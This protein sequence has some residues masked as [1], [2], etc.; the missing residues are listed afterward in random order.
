MANQTITTAVN[1]DDASISGL[2]DGETITINGGQLT[3]NADVRYNQQAAVPGNLTISS[4]LG[5][6]IT[7]DGTEVWELYF[8][9]STGNVPTQAALGSNTV[10]SS[11]GATGELLR[12]W[13]TGS[14]TP[15]AAG[16]AMPA[17]GW[18]KL[19]SKTGNFADNEVVTLPGGATITLTGPGRRSWIEVAGAQGSQATIPRLG[20]FVCTGDW[21]EIGATDGTDNQTI[22]TPFVAEIPAIQIETASGSGQYEWW[23]NANYRWNARLPVTSVGGA[24]VTITAE[25]ILGPGPAYPNGRRIRETAVNSTH[26]AQLTVT[27]T[28]VTAGMLSV[29]AYLKQETRQYVMVQLS[30]SGG[31]NRYAALVDLVNGTIVSNSSVGSPTSP[32]SS[33]S[34][35]GGGWYKV[36]VSASHST[37]NIQ[38]IVAISDSATPTLNASGLPTYTGV[39]TEGTYLGDFYLENPAA[40]QYISSTDNRGKYFYSDFFEGKIVLAKRGT[41]NAGIKPASGCKIRIPNIILTNAQALDWSRNISIYYGSA[42]AYAV[43]ISSSG[44][45]DIDKTSFI[46]R[47]S[48]GTTTSFKLTNSAVIGTVGLGT[49]TSTSLINNICF[50]AAFATAGLVIS[51][52][53][54]APT[55]TNS[56]F[57]TGYNGASLNVANAA[58]VIIQNCRCDTHGAFGSLAKSDTAAA[59]AISNCPGAVVENIDVIGSLVAVS[60]GSGHTL[61]NIKFAD[62]LNGTTPATGTTGLRVSGAFNVF[63]DG[64][65]PFDNLPSVNP[66]AR[67][68]NINGTSSGLEFRNF[69]TTTNPW[70]CT[71]QNVVN[72]LEIDPFG[73]E[74]QDVTV[75][76]LY[77]SGVS[78]VPFNSDANQRVFEFVNVHADYANTQSFDSPSTIFKGCRWTPSNTIES[79]RIGSHWN[80]AFVSATEGRFNIS[81]NEPLAATASQCAGSFSG[82]SGFTGGGQVSLTKLA[83]TVTW[84]FP[85]Y[86]VGHTGIA[87]AIGNPMCFNI[88]GTNT[89]MLEFDYQIDKNTGSFSAW[90]H[91]VNSARRASGGLSGT[92]SIVIE[93]ADEAALLRKPQIGD[94]IQSV[95]LKLP[96]GT[97][98]SNV[99]GTSITTSNNFTVDASASELFYFWK[100][101]AD[102]VVSSSIGFKLKVRLKVNTESGST[103]LS[104]VNIPTD[105]TA[106]DQL[107]QYPLPFD[108]QGL[109]SDIESGSRLQIYNVTTAT[110]LV[111]T[112]VSGTDYT[113]NYYVGTNVSDGDTIRIRLAKL[114]FLPQE[115]IAVADASGFA[116]ASNALTDEIYVSNGI[117]GSTVTEFVTDYPNIQVDINDPDQTTTVQRIYAWLR[118]IETTQDGV[119]QW[120]NA[121][122]P[123][124]EANYKINTAILDLK[125]DNTQPT[126]VIIGGGRLY[127]SDGAT[128]I[129]TLSSSIH[130][131]PNRVYVADAIS[132]TQTAYDNVAD[133]ILRRNTANIEG[134]TTGDSLNVRSLYGLVAQA[135]HNTYVDNNNK[136]VV[137]KSD[138]TTQL[139]TRTITNSPNAQPITGLNSD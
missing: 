116:A 66:S 131:D 102:E 126:P 37:G 14:L 123:T 55:I 107:I 91:L 121:V 13:A 127:R 44:R 114:G 15:E 17:T 125:L 139:A 78:S 97:T 130:M 25:S 93:T 53:F 20:N 51:R 2:L 87:K 119:E 72:L 104:Y 105:T 48:T 23:A 77:A 30:L 52:T 120:F 98:I 58:G 101:V 36:T 103:L 110:E 59:F 40:V 96:A 24:S 95:S 32:S 117:N 82:N 3:I 83:D 21:Y 89:Q 12:V 86:A 92:N 108:G 73:V 46:W 132:N 70:V 9:A 136:L 28:N 7:I 124:D 54:S 79:N 68:I 35:I 88:T 41:A 1:Y 16:G 69:G 81:G 18:I 75:R 67:L 61:K 84:T 43:N 122:D 129:A 74:I 62:C 11:G 6:S 137:T 60:T 94:Y 111:N 26:V 115:L 138:E 22:N 31:T 100:D 56:R 109:I 47:F 106:S 76:R 19:R 71:A 38:G 99:S 112:V 4:T 65:Y 42:L 49:I 34:S 80:E 57:T 90:K 50:G 118:Y 85:E 27:G 64:F 10:T 33:I 128:I 29:V 135:T 45:S 5:G 8:D 39:T 134:S 133:T 63:V 113:Y